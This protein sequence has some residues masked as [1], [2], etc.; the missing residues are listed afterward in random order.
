MRGTAGKIPDLG[1]RCVL[2][3]MGG[4]LGV[5]LRAFTEQFFEATALPAWEAV[6]VCNVVGSILIG[7]AYA[8]FDP[9]LPR[10]ADARLLPDELPR[11]TR[12]RHMLAALFITGAI[13]GLTTFSTFSLE[14]LH[15]IESARFLE[16]GF[17]VLGGIGLGLAGLILGVTFHHRYTTRRDRRSHTP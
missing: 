8:A 4:A 11:V 7:L 12:K 15:L 5:S 10:A 6:M 3:A 16:A 13:G 1:L 9:D 14:T 17:S 2:V